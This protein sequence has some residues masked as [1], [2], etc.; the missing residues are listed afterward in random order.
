MHQS[1][2]YR[3]FSLTCCAAAS[4]LFFAGG[5]SIKLARAACVTPNAQ[6]EV[7]DGSTQTPPS[8]IPTSAGTGKSNA[9]LAASN[10]STIQ[11]TNLVVDAPLTNHYAGWAGIN[12]TLDLTNATVTGWGGLHAD[13][14][15]SSIVLQGGSVNTTDSAIFLRGINLPGGGTSATLNGDVALTATG[16][17]PT[18]FLE[19]NGESSSF[20]M[21]GGSITGMT[22]GAML[23]SSSNRTVDLTNVVV[24]S[25]G[26]YGING[27]TGGNS[28]LNIRGGSITHA[29]T[30]TGGA[31]QFTKGGNVL[32]DGTIVKNTGAGAGVFI[33]NNNANS[34]LVMQNQF[35][36]EAHGQYAI[37]VNIQRNAKAELKDGKIT[38]YG[39]GGGTASMG[40]WVVGN[41]QALPLAAERVTVQTQ[42][43]NA[44]GIFLQT[45]ASTL[46]DVDVAVN[47]LAIGL[48]SV[49]AATSVQM[50]K[51]SINAAGANAGRVC[52]QWWP[53]GSGW[54]SG[55]FPEQHHGRHWCAGSVGF[56]R[57]D[58][59]WE[60]GDDGRCVCARP[61]FS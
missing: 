47:G 41:A 5:G 44:H 58:H 55:Q 4:L 14:A 32:V 50:T 61:V 22:G 38:T 31:V 11:G 57:H 13:G 3:R 10:A 8:G 40:I 39:A 42:G 20:V 29:S 37:G 16:T 34:N 21:N 15:G 9:A 1:A 52:Q 17:M 49:G 30:N 56:Q 19:A 6:C 36:V 46:Q 53:G 2:I 26:S 18:V 33:G 60:H 25:G 51:G 23:F 48:G 24:T 59:E 27:A 43:T 7:S 35:E 28:T 12:S 45:G 54:R